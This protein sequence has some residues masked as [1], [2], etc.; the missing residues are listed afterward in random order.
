M[1]YS[2]IVE[3]RRLTL[4]KQA[5]EAT[6]ALN[7]L[8]SDDVD[9]KFKKREELLLEVWAIENEL[10]SIL[11]IPLEELFGVAHSPKSSSQGGSSTGDSSGSERE[12]RK[13]LSEDLKLVKIA[14]LLRANPKGLSAKEISE[15][16]RDTYN[17]VSA[18]LAKHTEIYLKT[19]QKRS[20]VY[21][22][23]H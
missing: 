23:I 22:L 4:E 20:T 14:D 21:S 2:K 3:K 6:Q 18:H 15:R 9:S 11:D 7:K 10:V 19:G 16:I 8:T 5:A 13:S 17:T 12:R 1:N